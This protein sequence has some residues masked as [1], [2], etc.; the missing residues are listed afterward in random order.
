MPCGTEE[1]INPY[2]FA[3]GIALF[4][5]NDHDTLP[6]LKGQVDRFNQSGCESG[7]NDDA[8]NHRL[9]RMDPVGVKRRELFHINQTT[10]HSGTWKPE[11]L[12]LSKDVFMLPFLLAHKGSQKHGS[13][14]LGQTHQLR[15]DVLR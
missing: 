4:M 14:T 8:V 9:D 6:Q 11:L 15:D 13:G 10:I 3:L 2:R 12:N 7:T 1:P 5:T